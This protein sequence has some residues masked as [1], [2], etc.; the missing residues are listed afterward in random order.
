[1]WVKGFG[2]VIYKIQNEMLIVEVDSCGAEWKSVTDKKSQKEYLWNKKIDAW[3]YCAPILFPV[4]G[5]L[6]NDSYQWDGE[7]YS[8]PKHGFVLTC[9]L[10]CINKKRQNYICIVRNTRNICH[11]PF[12]I[13]IGNK[14]HTKGT[15][16]VTSFIVTNQ[17][18]YEMYFSL[19]T[20]PSF[21]CNQWDKL[22][23]EYPETIPAYR[24]NDEYLL[25]GRRDEIFNGG[26]EIILDSKVFQDGALI[27]PNLRSKFVIL[28][29][30]YG[31]PRIQ[32]ELC[33]PYLGIW[34]IPGEDYICIEPWFGI[35]DF[36][37]HNGK[38]EEKRG[39]CTLK[40]QEEFSYD[41]LVTFYE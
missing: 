2:H 21:C 40:P 35:D 17:S 28:K 25:D 39:I 12:S 9:H 24:M 4:I 16:L 11:L 3:Q 10:K 34:S 26:N 14:L 23:F 15:K 7:F 32:M 37:T 27:F 8:M 6:K 5:R 33:A 13:S 18:E 41:Y 31:K 1:M 29:S 22:E 30:A 38:I 19:G 20:H 36:T